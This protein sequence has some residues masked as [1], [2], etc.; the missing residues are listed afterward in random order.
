[1]VWRSP[2]FREHFPS[3][4]NI[5]PATV[6][7][8]AE[9]HFAGLNAQQL[10]EVAADLTRDVHAEVGRHFKVVNAPG[11]GVATL[12]LILVGVEPPRFRYVMS[13]P[14]QINALAVGR[15]DS[16][17]MTTGTLTISGKFTDSNTGKLEVAFV[18]PVYPQVMDLPPPATP[19]RTLDFAEQASQQFAA[20]LV[21]AMIHQR[22][23]SQMPPK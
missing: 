8:G 7:H 6:Y 10:D 17:G 20:N 3:A 9:A 19:G 21:R 12:E 1:M 2:E 11:P 15:P 22:Q 13:G 18:A 23:S 5:P 4:Y 16:G 14:Y